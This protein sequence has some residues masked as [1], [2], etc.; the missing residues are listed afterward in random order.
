[1]AEKGAV[2]NEEEEV[3]LEINEFFRKQFRKISFEDAKEIVMG[4]GFTGV[5]YSEASKTKIMG[6]D[7]KFWVWETLEEATRPHVDQLS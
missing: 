3:C 4:L 2:V 5:T 7:D 1:M 6:L